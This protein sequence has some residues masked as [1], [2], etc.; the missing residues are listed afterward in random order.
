MAK[1]SCQGVFM[2]T[3]DPHCLFWAGASGQSLP[4]CLWLAKAY[5]CG[6]NGISGGIPVSWGIRVWEW[7]LGRLRLGEGVQ[8]SDSHCSVIRTKKSPLFGLGGQRQFSS[9]VSLI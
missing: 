1:Q 4:T 9:Q 2:V 8:G 7:G 6:Q 3:T 5:T